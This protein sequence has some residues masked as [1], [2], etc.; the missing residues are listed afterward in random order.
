MRRIQR[1]IFRP[2][3]ITGRR[4]MSFTLF[5]LSFGVSKIFEPSKLVLTGSFTTWMSYS[6]EQKLQKNISQQTVKLGITTL[7]AQTTQ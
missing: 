7:V 5:F 1:A 3:T 6:I 2:F 4:A